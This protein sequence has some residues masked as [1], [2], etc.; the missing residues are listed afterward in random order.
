MKIIFA[1][2]ILSLAAVLIFGYQSLAENQ[3]SMEDKDMMEKN[4]DNLAV[5]TFAGGCF[6]CTESDLEKVKGVKEAV[7]GYTGGFKANPTYEEVSDGTTGHTEAIQVYYDPQ[8]VT[9]EE[10]LD[11]FWRHINPTDPGGQFVDRGTQYR[12]EIFYHTEDQ[13]QKAMASKKA[14]E[15][16]MVFD[17]PIVT[18]ITRFE[19]FYPAEDYHQDY[20]K[21]HGIRYKYYRHASGRD[22]FIEKAWKDKDIKQKKTAPW[23]KPDD[24]II[25]EKLTPLQY[26]V[27]Q[28][29]GTEP[30]FKNEYWDNKEEGIYVDIVSGEPLFSS[31]DKY[32]SGTGWPSFTKPLEK[33]NIIEKPD[34]GL[35]MSRTE[36]RSRHGDSHLGHVFPDGP[37][38]TGLRYCINSASLRFIPKEKLEAEGYGKYL[39]M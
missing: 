13:K 6:W 26:T 10:L 5:A 11:V 24:R 4:A 23:S 37:E 34:K 20:Y 36:V 15:Q 17:K 30:P 2:I 25:K 38:P 29:E 9:Y 28:K 31:T 1:M 21:N 12:S 27:T 7:S 3:N 39:G 35:F 33:E 8:V 16:S 19:K 32:D 22:Q 14:L 18:A